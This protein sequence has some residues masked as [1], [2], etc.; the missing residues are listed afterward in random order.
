MENN[1]IEYKATRKLLMT[2]LFFSVGI[3]WLFLIGMILLSM[4]S[5]EDIIIVV[6][7]LIVVSIL[8]VGIALVVGYINVKIYVFTKNRIEI[9]CRKKKISCYERNDIKELRYVR[10]SP[11]YFA[12]AFNFNARKGASWCLYV[13]TKDGQKKTL[14]WFNSSIVEKLQTELY[15]KLVT[16]Y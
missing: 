15:G 11:K 12:S 7:A 10:V 8:I 6:I 1:K 14:F 4:P 9:F 16:I 5:Y 3:T 13:F 2:I